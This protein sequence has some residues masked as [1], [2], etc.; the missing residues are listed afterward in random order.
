MESPL[1]TNA[2]GRETYRL[3]N[4]LSIRAHRHPSIEARPL[5]DLRVMMAKD[6]ESVKVGWLVVNLNAQYNE[7]WLRKTA[8]KKGNRNQLCTI[9]DQTLA[10]I[11]QVD[12]DVKARPYG[13]QDCG[14]M[15]IRTIGEDNPVE[16]WATIDYF[17]VLCHD[18]E[19]LFAPETADDDFWR[20]VVRN[21]A[22]YG[23]HIGQYYEY[24]LRKLV[25]L[26]YP[27]PPPD[28]AEGAA[29]AAIQAVWQDDRCWARPE[30]EEG[31]S[32]A[33]SSQWR[34]NR[35]GSGHWWQS[36]WRS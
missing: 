34:G 22:E 33:S 3:A 15:K 30:Y 5:S 10:V 11:I 25:H 23:T 36:E 14:A 7:T 4:Y 16:G 28:T 12:E 2:S 24:S 9:Q 32:S 17:H 8:G 18:S 1:D 29:P 20:N 35:Y 21:L 31:G 13:S 27:P 19:P 26:P 6:G